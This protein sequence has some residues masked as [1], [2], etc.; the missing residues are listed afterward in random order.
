M[1]LT[2]HH[3]R[4]SGRKLL[5]AEAGLLQPDDSPARDMLKSVGIMDV[6]G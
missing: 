2:T 4:D 5:F 6:Q 3:H 1:R